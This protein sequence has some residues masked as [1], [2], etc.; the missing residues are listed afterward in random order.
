MTGE[1]RTMAPLPVPAESRT[2]FVKM[3]TVPVYEA[4]MMPVV[5]TARE[6]KGMCIAEDVFGMNAFFGG[7][8]FNECNPSDVESYRKDGR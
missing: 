5:V 1:T 4:R 8:D 2:Y 7:Y 3:G 6:C